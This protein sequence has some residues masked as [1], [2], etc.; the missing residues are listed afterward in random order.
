MLG[1]Q[2]SLLMIAYSWQPVVHSS[3]CSLGY[4]FFYFRDFCS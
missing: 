4:I 2:M 3:N 1:A